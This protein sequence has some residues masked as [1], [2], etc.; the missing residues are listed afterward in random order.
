MRFYV[1]FQSVLLCSSFKGVLFWAMPYIYIYIGHCS[2]Q[3]TL[4]KRTPQNTLE[5][6]VESHQKLGLNSNFKVINVLLWIKTVS[7]MFNNKYKL[8]ITWFYVK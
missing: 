8:K 1:R 6:N 5:S 3:N 4:K 7:T 2:K